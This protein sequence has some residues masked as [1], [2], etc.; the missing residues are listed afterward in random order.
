MR[1]K[2]LC[3]LHAIEKIIKRN[4]KGEACRKMSYGMKGALTVMI[5]QRDVFGQGGA[6][7]LVPDSTLQGCTSQQV[8]YTLCLLLFCKNGN[9]NN[10]L[11]ALL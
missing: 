5:L 7:A 1:I 8:P 11:L 6:R 10:H 4:N 2:V 9:N 3:Q